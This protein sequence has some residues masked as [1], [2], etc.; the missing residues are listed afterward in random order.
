M[1]IANARA[2][3]PLLA[4]GWPSATESRRRRPV[5]S[6]A[7]RAARDQTHSF[8]RPCRDLLEAAVQRGEAPG[9]QLAKLGDRILTLEGKPQ[10]YGTQFDW[11]DN[12]EVAPLPIEDITRVDELRAQVGLEPLAE[13]TARQRRNVEENGERPPLDRE[14]HRAL[15]HEWA[16]RV[17]WR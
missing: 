6:L 11:D 15:A 1:H 3:E 17:G 2:L 8:M 16:Q 9:W 5:R 4:N 10:R 7:D 12:G 13:A 14:A